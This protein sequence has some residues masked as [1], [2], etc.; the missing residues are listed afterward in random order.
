[1]YALFWELWIKSKMAGNDGLESSDEFEDEEEEVA[2]AVA[3]AAATE[4]KSGDGNEYGDNDKM[5]D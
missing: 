5:R 1:V 2:V 4:V 3:A